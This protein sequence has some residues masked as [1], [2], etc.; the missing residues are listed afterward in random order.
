[1]FTS[2]YRSYGA[3]PFLWRIYKDLAPLEPFFNP[4]AVG[5]GYRRLV[6]ASAVDEIHADLGDGSGSAAMKVAEVVR[7]AF[8]VAEE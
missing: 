7:C 8:R 2:G 5:L 3:A 6:S 1:M 4:T